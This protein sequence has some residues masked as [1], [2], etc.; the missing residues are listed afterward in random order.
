MFELTK[1]EVLEEINKINDYLS[2]CMWMD[3][4]I[5]SF[6]WGELIMSGAIDLTYNDNTAIEIFFGYPHFANI[7]FSIK[8]DTSKPFIELCSDEECM[9][10]NKKYQV[11][12]GNYIFKIYPED[13][14]ET[15]MYIAAKKISSNIIKNPFE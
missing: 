14:E 7:L 2:K 1:D 10:F 9:E 13:F 11:E 4:E 3:F 12:H 15:P 8:T 6:H 5:H